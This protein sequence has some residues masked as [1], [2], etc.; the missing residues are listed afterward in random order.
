MEIYI[1]NDKPTVRMSLEEYKD[2]LAS[3]NKY[4]AENEKLKENLHKNKSLYIEL[5]KENVNLKDQLKTIENERMA[6]LCE[7][8]KLLA[9]HQRLK[10]NLE[11]ALNERRL[12]KRIADI[13]QANAIKAEEQTKALLD[14][15][16]AIEEIIEG[17]S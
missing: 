5:D 15:L 13:E 8:E 3:I 4:G 9:E 2:L 7:S 1:I 16:A 12:F 14:K 10:E 11:N 6:I 17:E